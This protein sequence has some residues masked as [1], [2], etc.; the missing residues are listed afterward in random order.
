[1]AGPHV[2]FTPCLTLVHCASHSPLGDYYKNRYSLFYDFLA[3]LVTYMMIMD[4]YY[5]QV[6]LSRGIGNKQK[7]ATIT[8][9]I[10]WIGI[11]IQ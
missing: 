6:G 7:H 1:M 10:L 9:A 11:A 8:E 4:N 5:T 2:S 3:M